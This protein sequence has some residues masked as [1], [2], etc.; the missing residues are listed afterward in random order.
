MA[1]KSSR[2][3]FIQRAAGAA[4]ASATLATVPFAKF[5]TLGTKFIPSSFPTGQRVIRIRV[6]NDDQSWTNAMGS[7]MPQDV[8]N[9]IEDL[10]PTTLNRYF[11]GP[12]SPSQ[13]LPASLGSKQLTVHEFLQRSINACKNPNNTTMFPRLSYSYY[14]D[15]G[16]ETFLSVAQQMFKLCNS[17]YPPQT[18]LSIDNYGG[19]N[20]T[21]MT[22]A[23]AL[24]QMGW[25]GLCWDACG[26]AGPEG[27]ATF[28]M[29]CVDPDTGEVNM[30]NMNALETIGGY[31]E[32]EAQI[33]FPGPMDIF[34]SHSPD[35]M[36]NMLTLLA[37]GQMQGGY[38]LMYPILQ[39]KSAE[40]ISGFSWDS[41]QIFTSPYGGFGGQSL[42]EVMKQLMQEYN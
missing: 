7:Y 11:S 5:F 19:D 21:V 23:S 18:L 41:T 27:Y 42:Y 40:T 36:A 8:L 39:L 32:F 34:S 3:D 1:E 4:A 25:K 14:A 15:N 30:S 22:L 29:I 6:L 28:A 38:H 24:F 2:R 33:D 26:A 31:G 13:L 17:L 12:Q 20:P 35:I 16:T 10:K 9:I 37:V